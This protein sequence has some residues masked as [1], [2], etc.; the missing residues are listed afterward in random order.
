METTALCFRGTVVSQ[1]LRRG[2]P[3]GVRS[4][5]VA[6]PTLHSSAFSQSTRRLR[7]TASAASED[8][9]PEPAQSQRIPGRRHRKD[10]TNTRGDRR[11]ETR[12][13][14][15]PDGV[16]LEN[17]AVANQ[18]LPENTHVS[19]A[20]V[21]VILLSIDPFPNPNT[22]YGTC[23]SAPLVT[24]L[25]TFYQ[26]WQLLQTYTRD[27]GLTLFFPNRRS[28]ICYRPTLNATQKASLKTIARNPPRF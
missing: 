25:V 3:A 27:S 26:Y 6:P 9:D 24:L 13:M 28:R 14:V 1:Q 22:I 19:N 16:S 7:C 10:T 17:I 15:S 8:L 23:L 11:L 21:N 20:Q 2:W 4:S 18:S 12:G 5:A